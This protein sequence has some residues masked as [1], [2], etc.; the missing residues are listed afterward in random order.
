MIENKKTISA[1]LFEDPVHFAPADPMICYNDT[2]DELW[3][4]YTARR[5]DLN[6]ENHEWYFGTQVGVAVSSDGGCTFSYKG[7]L[8]LNF[9]D[10]LN[11]F[12]APEIIK[13]DGIYHMFVTYSSGVSDQWRKDYTTAHYTSHDL[14]NWDF[15][16]ILDMEDGVIDI[17]IIP[18]D[19]GWRMWYKRCNDKRCGC[20]YAESTDLINW[21]EKGFAIHD[22]ANE[23]PNVF[24]WKD[25]Y[26]LVVDSW[27]GLSVYKSDD[28]V[29]WKYETHILNTEGSRPC[30]KN[31]GHHADVY[32]SGDRAFVIYF[33][34]NY[35]H[36]TDSM[37][38][39]DA[40]Y[41]KHRSYI[42]AA[43]LEIK[44]GKL[45]CDRNK[46]CESII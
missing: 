17:S 20:Y 34:Y 25:S 7:E 27:D 45:Y 1:P 32:V 18:I 23:G 31:N 35:D 2:T 28:A 33:T 10:G 38:D 39:A 12:W 22:Y 29:D 11:T 24:Y 37:D 13:A 36:Y 6:C 42:H 8:S 40:T 4:F 5:G 46:E 26:W 44:D 41:A 21:D 15:V 3:M 16:S 9:E 30:D 43:E 14:W 19:G